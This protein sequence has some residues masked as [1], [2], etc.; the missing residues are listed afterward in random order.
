[1]TNGPGL[2]QGAARHRARELEGIAVSARP[3]NSADGGWHLGGWPQAGDVWIVVSLD[4]REVLD[5]GGERPCPCPV[6]G[7]SP[8]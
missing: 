4:R 1:M 6:T 2:E 8:N 5:D 7:S 3:R